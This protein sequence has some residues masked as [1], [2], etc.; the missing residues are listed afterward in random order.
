VDTAESVG[1]CFSR[2]SLRKYIC[3]SGDVPEASEG[4]VLVDYAL[5]DSPRAD[6]TA[7]LAARVTTVE[8]KTHYWLTCLVEDKYSAQETAYQ[9][10]KFVGTHKPAR[11]LIERL[12]GW[13]YLRNEIIRQAERYKLE[14]GTLTF[15]KTS[16][17]RDAKRN[18]ILKFSEACQ[19][20]RVHIVYAGWNEL[21]FTSLINYTGEKTNKSRHDDAAD[22]CGYLAILG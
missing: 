5:S 21:L 15:F 18:R 1:V 3:S 11:T 22:V 9:I 13:Q 20:G 19:E 17:K 14:I 4:I 10:A 2:D 12:T 8:E 16:K 7:L 6:N